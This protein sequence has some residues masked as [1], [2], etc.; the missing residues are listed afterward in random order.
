MKILRLDLLAF[1]PFTERELTFEAG[2]YGLHVVYGPN[3]AGKSSALRALRQLLF[4]IE[5]R[6]TDNFLHSHQDLR[7]KAALRS[8]DGVTLE[9]IRRKGNKNTLRGA[10]GESLVDP[11]LLEEML[12]NVDESTFKQQFGIDYE[13]LV[14][15][16]RAI[17]NGSDVGQILF[18]A[19]RGAANLSRVQA[20]LA[21][22]AAAIFR[23]NAALPVLNAA[24]RNY[25]EARRL[26][27]D[28]Q[29]PS[30]QWKTHHDALTDA[31]KQKAKA[32]EELDTLTAEQ[33]KLT[34]IEEALPLIAA[35]VRHLEALQLLGSG[36]ELPES[37]S[38]ERRQLMK[39][40]AVAESKEKTCAELLAEISDSMQTLEVP[41]D[42][43]DQ[44]TA[45]KDLQTGLGA[46]RKAAKDR[47]GL[48]AQERQLS[49]DVAGLLRELG[50]DIPLD[51]V[52]RLRVPRPQKARIQELATE[53][54]RLV[55][56]VNA[57]STALGKLNSN[58]KTLEQ[59]LAAA[60]PVPNTDE[61]RRVVGR[62]QKQ[63]DLE[64]QHAAGLAEL[65]RRI[66]QAKLELAQ[67]GPWKG[68]LVELEA[69]PVPAA[70]TIDRFE[71]ELDAAASVVRDLE[72]EQKEIEESAR[73]NEQE[74]E[75]L[76]LQQDVP[77][78]DDLTRARERRESLWQLIRSVWERGEPSVASKSQAA[79]ESDTPADLGRSFELSVT[80]ADEVAD[81]LRREAR[82]VAAKARLL[83]ERDRISERAKGNSINLAEARTTRSSAQQ[84]WQDSWLATNLSPLTPKEMRAWLMRH[85][86]LVAAAREIRER[87]ASL[88]E[89]EGVLSSLRKELVAS[90]A[91]LSID[92]A[93][94]HPTLSGLLEVAEE[95]LEQLES[96]SR[97]RSVV[98]RDCLKL[99]LQ[100]PEA[101]Q[102][103]A[104]ANATLV[105]WQ[106]KWT[107]AV[108][109]L[110][111]DADV[112]PAQANVVISTIDDL[113]TRQGEVRKLAERI[114]GIDVD[115]ERYASSV[116]QF[117]QH[118]F[119]DLKEASIEQA[120]TLIGSRLS[121]AQQD[122]AKLEELSAQQ[123]REEKKLS[124]AR[125]KC[126]ELQALLVNLCREACC[127]SLE[128]L[129][130]VEEKSA[131]R[132][133]AREEVAK[134]EAQLLR[135]AA[136]A[137]LE[138]FLAEAALAQPD[139]IASRLRELSEAIAKLESMR[140]ELDQALG[141]EETELKR[142]N[143]SAQAAEANDAAQSLLA[144]IQTDAARYVRL[145]LAAAVLARAVERY[146]ER[147]Q[148][149]VLARASELFA[150]LTLGSFTG[151]KADYNEK[152]E[153]VLVGVR[154][155]GKQ[156]I[157]T[158]GMSDGTCDQMYLALRLASLEEFL[159][160]NS[161]LPFIVDD[162]LIKF[163]D[164]RAVAALKAL[165]RLSQQTQVIFFTHH[166][167][168]VTLARENLGDDVLFVHNLA[169]PSVRS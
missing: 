109:P 83:V 105:A 13:Q 129:P 164:V 145:K 124:E 58:V 21:D 147:H 54:E 37:F 23:P 12:G 163:D 75:E 52:E 121:R 67:L 33:R 113:L 119:A 155:G 154:P 169:G 10:D 108:Q 59:E 79:G 61:L 78:E 1:G 139:A 63:G 135:L 86:A 151:L 34:R 131:G 166:E 42:L 95:T 6:T 149:P 55:A 153:V 3:E 36:P 45:I 27:K 168:L 66:K 104:S 158:S 142:M 148:G 24:L 91:K 157:G 125:G 80:K 4:G 117:A 41:P 144:Q 29:L 62:V 103:L 44:E 76:R 100:I 26:V 11:E 136:G 107:A 49:E 167:H 70:E 92:P 126:R 93:D 9:F 22:D 90:L 141:R 18:D 130:V 32:Q 73:R 71:T 94:R 5:T 84:N 123:V 64:Q 97:Q 17:A 74:I 134:V 102:E 159:R 120:V 68:T 31:R 87:Q 25:A 133:K 122:R 162:I 43:L 115:N 160:N 40:L 2:E 98:E 56:G 156:T 85:S 127:E 14:A 15:G 128:E 38:E 30:A 146:R 20:Q 16:G 39:E 140:S 28:S 69:L 114:Q 88:D 89:S 47:P 161:P 72:R 77:T 101:E 112:S 51:E 53:H 99:R 46:Y 7:I 82:Q 60:K 48:E 57:A 110:S 35:R 138:D 137:P 19:A 150:E 96:E 143:G 132:R 50:K 8:P 106:D 81:R 116:R 118:H 111:L 165:A 152:G 65:A